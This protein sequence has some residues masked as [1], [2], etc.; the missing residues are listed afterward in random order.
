MELGRLES[1]IYDITGQIADGG[2][3][4]VQLEP[5]THSAR[6]ALESMAGVAVGSHVQEGTA[7]LHTA[8]NNNRF[9]ID[10]SFPQAQDF[11]S[12]GQDVNITVGTERITGRVARVVPQG[13]RNNVTIELNSGSLRGGEIASVIVSGGSSNHANV[14]PLS[15]LRE[16]MNGYFILFT[17]SVSRRFGSSYYL[18]IQR[19]EPGRRD[20]VNVAISPMWGIPL[21]EEPIVINSSMPV[22]AGTRVRI[23]SSADIN[24]TR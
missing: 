11:I 18:R 15:A 20:N 7:V 9:Y 12:V 14:V 22:H 5:G 13:G 2:I 24:P 3:I 1:Q 8:M 23:V 4:E 17:E 10:A 21:S 16:D 6:T 19:V